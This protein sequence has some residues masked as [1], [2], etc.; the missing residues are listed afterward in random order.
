M[1]LSQIYQVKYR[2]REES[3]YMFR[4]KNMETVISFDGSVYLSLSFY[5][6]FCFFHIPF[7][8]NPIFSDLIL[9]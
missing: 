3:W 5:S 8:N 6:C 4:K 7:Q 1:R 9:I 2:N